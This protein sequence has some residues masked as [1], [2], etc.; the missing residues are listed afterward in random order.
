MWGRTKGGPFSAPLSSFQWGCQYR[1]LARSRVY[2]SEDMF[3]LTRTH[4]D[5]ECG[6]CSLAL[7]REKGASFSKRILWALLSRTTDSHSRIIIKLF[8]KEKRQIL[9]FEDAV[10]CMT[11]YYHCA[12]KQ[13]LMD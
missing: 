11:T 7:D 9:D 2:K 8:I 13:G 1:Q 3:V 5:L 12:K 10:R 4:C 6:E